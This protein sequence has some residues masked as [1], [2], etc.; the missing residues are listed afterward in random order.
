V[1]LLGRWYGW[2]AALRM[3]ARRPFCGEGLGAWQPAYALA[4][5]PGAPVDW[6][7]AHNFYLNTLAETGFLGLLGFAALLWSFRRVWRAGWRA[8]DVL[9]EELG[10]T[11]ALTG[12]AVVALF[13]ATWAGEPG[14]AFLAL[15]AFTLRRRA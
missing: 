5:A 8:P 6:P 3:I 2:D 9:P 10:L 1:S 14:Y 7:H 13:D 11:A 12:T 15:A 4:R